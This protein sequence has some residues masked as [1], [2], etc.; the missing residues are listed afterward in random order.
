MTGCGRWIG[1][2]AR[3]AKE[4]PVK[5][6]VCPDEMARTAPGKRLSHASIF[7]AGC[8]LRLHM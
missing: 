5:S 4:E 6:H 1:S 8:Q 2:C 7:L 3:L